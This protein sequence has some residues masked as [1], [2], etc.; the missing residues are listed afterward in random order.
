MWKTITLYVGIIFIWIYINDLKLVEVFNFGNHPYNGDKIKFD[1]TISQDMLDYITK[2]HN[3]NIMIKEIIITDSKHKFLEWYFNYKVR[4]ND[5][6]KLFQ[7][8]SLSYFVF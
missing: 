5:Q 2:K 8:Y 6:W 7:Y 4:I 1:L 3:N